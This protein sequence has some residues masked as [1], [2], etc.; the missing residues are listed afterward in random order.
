MSA[1]TWSKRHNFKHCKITWK[2][3]FLKIVHCFCIPMTDQNNMVRMPIWECNVNCNF[4]FWFFSVFQW[5][6]RTIWQ[7]DIYGLHTSLIWAEPSILIGVY[8]DNGFSLKII[9]SL[10]IFQGFVNIQHFNSEFSLSTYC[11]DSCELDALLGAGQ[12]KISTSSTSPTSQTK[13]KFW[14]K[15]LS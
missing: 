12:M 10:I 3:A 11:D 5:Q 8:W 6:P 4:E 1:L 2:Q 15:E 14:R 9:Q 7:E 13:F